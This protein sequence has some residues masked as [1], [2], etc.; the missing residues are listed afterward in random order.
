MKFSCDSCHARY[1]IADEKLRGKILRV[2]CK[3]CGSSI[4]LKEPDDELQETTHDEDATHVVRVDEIRRALTDSEVVPEPENTSKFVSKHSLAPPVPASELPEPAVERPEW[5][6]LVHREEIGPLRMDELRERARAAAITPRTY[7][8]RDGMPGWERLLKVAELKEVLDLIPV[9]ASR[10]TVRPPARNSTIPP[11]PPR[12]ADGIVRPPQ[13]PPTT[14]TELRP[15]P[16]AAIAAGAPAPNGALAAAGAPEANGGFAPEEWLAGPET[17]PPQI[18]SSPGAKGPSTLERLANERRAERARQTQDSVD[19]LDDIRLA[20]EARLAAEASSWAEEAERVSGDRFERIE[21]DAPAVA[22][23]NPQEQV[24]ET[25][26]ETSAEVVAADAPPPMGIAE[27]QVTPAPGSFE[28]ANGS[29]SASMNGPAV[30]P[31]PTEPPPVRPQEGGSFDDFDLGPDMREP[32]GPDSDRDALLKAV[33]ARH[34]KQARLRAG[35]AS[36]AYRQPEKR[37][38]R[39]PVN[40]AVVVIVA[41]VALAAVGLSFRHGAP[42]EGTVAESAPAPQPKPAVAAPAEKGGEAAAVTAAADLSKKAAPTPEPD[43]A[44]APAEAEAPKKETPQPEP[45]PAPAVKETLAHAVPAA[46]PAPG[47][48]D[49]DINK[50]VAAVNPNDPAA[51]MKRVHDLMPQIDQM[52]IA[53]TRKKIPGFQLGNMNVAITLAPTGVV[54]KAVFE[55]AAFG[56]T[57]LGRCILKQV[58]AVV[59]PPFQGAPR[60]T[61]VPLVFEKADAPEAAPRPAPG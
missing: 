13:A 1:T 49:L 34:E 31:A 22:P 41:V 40:A 39:A 4:L 16:S 36:T 11:P 59:M 38:R 43:Q 27:P 54:T 47:P 52:C 24:P 44:A 53:A 26:D 48:D 10:V 5:Y 51:L 60:Q 45:A 28:F 17:T 46:A 29:L 23:E 57:E 15:V 42:T 12:P 33:E 30:V 56:Q 32:T 61:N 58:K 8:W 37:A 3:R 35:R 25:A 7:V 9:S 2:R 50:A 14:S 18:G 20:E 55:K 21:L 19:R 6:V